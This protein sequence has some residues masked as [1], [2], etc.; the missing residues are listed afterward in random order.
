MD[1]D[2]HVAGSSMQRWRLPQT[3]I[4]HQL[5]HTVNTIQDFWAVI[6]GHENK[7]KVNGGVHGADS[8]CVALYV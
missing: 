2:G 7:L 4:N 5:D 3:L 1:S 8:C 6:H